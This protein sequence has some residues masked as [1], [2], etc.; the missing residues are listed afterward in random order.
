MKVVHGKDV[1]GIAAHLSGGVRRRPPGH[2]FFEW[3]ERRSS[4]SS[5]PIV[6]FRYNLF[7]HLGTASVVGNSATRFIPSCY[8]L[9]YDWLQVSES[10]S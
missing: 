3:A 5:S 9:L 10:S 2:L 6:A 8:E 7:F 4:G 1:G